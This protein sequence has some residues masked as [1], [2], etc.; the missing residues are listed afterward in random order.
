MTDKESILN[1]MSD[2]AMLSCTPRMPTHLVGPPAVL[3]DIKRMAAAD[4]G[5]KSQN[6]ITPVEFVS[7]P[8]C[9]KRVQL[10]FPRS[11]RKRIR[12]KWTKDSHNWGDIPQMFLID[13]NDFYKSMEMPPGIFR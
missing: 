10:L 11:K 9:V 12:K 13:K 7:N 1:I 5:I 2:L 8:Y 6:L 3:E 4:L